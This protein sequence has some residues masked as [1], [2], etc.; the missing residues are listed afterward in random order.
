MLAVYQQTIVD[1]LGNIITGASVTIRDA[2][3]GTI[4][5]L[6]DDE[7]GASPTTNPVLTDSEGFVRVYVAA[8]KY[9]VRAEKDDF[10]KTHEDVLI[11][12]AIKLLPPDGPI[13]VE[14]SP[15]AGLNSD[16]EVDIDTRYI[17][18]NTDG[19]LR[20][21]GMT[22]SY[23]GQ[24]VTLANIRSDIEDIVYIV[25]AADSVSELPNQFRIAKTLAML[26]FMPYTFV[27]SAR[28]MKWCLK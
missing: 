16:L 23:D 15:P 10:S 24:E 6:Y 5:P 11:G 4:V 1:E 12:A 14:M 19:V 7:A 22:P 13:N 21:D 17:E 28:V 26:Q 18:L 25:P 27:Y 9:Q 2:N 20:I 8:G 3:L